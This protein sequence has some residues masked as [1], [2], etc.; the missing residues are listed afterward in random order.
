MY[1]MCTSI[2]VCIYAAKGPTSHIPARAGKGHPLFAL[3]SSLFPSHPLFSLLSSLFP[4]PSS[5]FPLPLMPHAPSYPILFPLPH[6]PH[7][8]S[9]PMLQPL[10]CGLKLLVYVALSY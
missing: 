6:M 5:L 3:P 10:V 1:I 4:L 7:A 9:Y 8:P 2:Y